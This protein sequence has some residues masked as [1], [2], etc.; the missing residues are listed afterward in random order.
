MLTPKQTPLAL[1]GMFFACSL[2][3]GEPEKGK[4]IVALL[5]VIAT[6]LYVLVCNHV[7]ERRNEKRRSEMRR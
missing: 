5:T 3:D 1:I 2:A 4:L 7:N 6:V